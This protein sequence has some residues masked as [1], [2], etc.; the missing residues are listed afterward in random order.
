MSLVLTHSTILVRR[1]QIV[2]LNERPQVPNLVTFLGPLILLPW[3]G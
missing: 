3:A 1:G 2:E